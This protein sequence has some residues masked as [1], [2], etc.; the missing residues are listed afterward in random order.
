MA[1]MLAE[2]LMQESD[3]DVERLD[4]LFT[5]VA[6]RKPTDAERSACIELLQSMQ[7]R[8]TADEQDAS[9]LLAIGDTPRNQ[10][11]NLVEHAAWS[12]LAI[13]V[14]ASDA[15]ISLY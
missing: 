1:R 7:A 15:A 14:L 12:Q 11:L 10:Q 4:Q 13:T 9:A 2:R 3:N 8:Y 6:S 5:L